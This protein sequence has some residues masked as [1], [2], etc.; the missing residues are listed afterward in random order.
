MRIRA[1]G[2]Q[3]GLHAGARSDEMRPALRH[4]IAKAI[5]TRTA[6]IKPLLFC[7]EWYRIHGDTA[8]KA[9]LAAIN[10]NVE[11]ER[12]ARWFKAENGSEREAVLLAARG[13]LG[14]G[15]LFHCLS[16]RHR[17]NFGINQ[18]CALHLRYE[19]PRSAAC[20]GAALKTHAD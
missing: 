17:V 7:R 20:A 15:V 12:P 19:A 14:S 3:E 1:C 13:L 18:R 9:F 6:R 4:A 11:F 2:Q 16:L 5:F 10:I 8:I